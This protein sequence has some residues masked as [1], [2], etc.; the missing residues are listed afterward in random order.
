[1]SSNPSRAA[2][3]I[4]QELYA[5]RQ[6]IY[7]REVHGLFARLR[8][9]AVVSLLGLYYIVPWFRWD[10]RQAVLF[11]LPARKFYIFGLVFWPQDFF[12]LSGLLIIAALSLF[13]FTALAGRLWCGYACPQTVW[14]EAFMWLER[15]IEGEWSK[16]MKLD[17][18]PWSGHKVLVKTIKHTVWIVFAL[19][20]GFTFVGYFTPILE[21]G[22]K[23]LT[24]ST[25]PWE[26]FWVFFYGFATYGNAGWLREQVCI[27]MCPY[28]RFQSAMFDKN[29]LVISYDE[30]R[31]EPRGGRKRGSDPKAQG[32]GDCINCRIC[33]QVCPTGI[34][35]R[36]G[37]QYQCIG[38]AA[39]IDACDDVMDRMGYARGLVLYTT[40]NTLEGRPTRVLR[41]R[42]IVYAVILVM[43][44]GAVVYGIATRNPVGL[45]V[46]RDR[47]ALFRETN[48]GFIENIYTLKILN[49]SDRDY[50]F[51]ITA[52][53]IPGLKLVS[54]QPTVLVVGGAVA[55]IVVRVQLDFADLKAS[56]NAINFTVQ[57][58]DDDRMKAQEPARFLGPRGIE[59]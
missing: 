9:T 18:A 13:F 3:G 49:K 36:D 1:M 40:E 35:I 2:E 23:L 45:D 25:G 17:K 47:N 42:V 54:D 57:A 39:C 58:V 24:F 14:T 50:T 55:N 34:D 7:P 29:T 44:L 28:A 51:G 8:V 30:N 56:T 15:I 38:C 20:T 4:E 59:R 53:G 48:E 52:S 12:Y 33:V 37:L 46:I 26:T 6:K 10:D 16:Q 5:K 11:D 21:L 27:Y 31:G 22:A 41:P 19:W 32:L 43:L